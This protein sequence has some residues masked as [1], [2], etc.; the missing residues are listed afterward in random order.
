MTPNPNRTR[1][2]LEPTLKD[3][4]D[5]L[6]HGKLVGSRSIIGSIRVAIARSTRIAKLL[7]RGGRI[8]HVRKDGTS[9]EVE[10]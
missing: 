5:I 2:S 9:K 6:D 10:L 7:K 3:K 1:L 4:Q 8:V